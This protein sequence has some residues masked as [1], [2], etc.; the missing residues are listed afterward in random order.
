[1]CIAEMLEVKYLMIRL[2]IDTDKLKL[3]ADG[4]VGVTRSTRGNIMLSYG[5]FEFA[6]CVRGH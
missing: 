3:G 1:M 2:L 5:V 4:K 6:S